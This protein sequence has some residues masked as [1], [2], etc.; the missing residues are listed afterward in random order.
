MTR[1]ARGAK[2][3]TG[4]AGATEARTRRGAGEP[5]EGTARPARA[6]RL[7]RRPIY[8]PDLA[9]IQ[10]A[11][12]SDFAR[13]AAPFLLS[14]FRGSGLARGRV[15]DLGC[16]DGAWLRR[17]TD[18]GYAAT[19]IDQ[20]LALVRIARSVA[21]HAAVRLGSVYATPIPACDAVTAL[22]EV[23]NYRPESSRRPPTLAATF[24]RVA[25]AL[26]PGGWFVFDLLVAGEGPPMDYRVWS[27]GQGWT[28][29]VRV[30]EDRPRRR[31]TRDIV[32][33]R[34]RGREWHRHVER[35]VLR[36]PSRAEVAAALRAAG[37][38]VRVATRYGEAALLPRRAAF[39]ARR[40]AAR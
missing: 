10:H 37:F 33:Y 1:P 2:R 12:F 34:R 8:G 21:P 16:G 4:D 14:L 39:I 28:V 27:E 31:L 36:V 30:E 18:A 13:R 15:V 38:T 29:L 25:A 11:G 17:L 22:G 19:G 35:H 7:R 40:R 20:S 24:R 23:L 6:R 26:P 32:T 5:R 3:P 9:H